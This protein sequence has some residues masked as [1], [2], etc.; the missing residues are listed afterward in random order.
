MRKVLSWNNKG[1]VMKRD[2]SPVATATAPH[3]HTHTPLHTAFCSY[4]MAGL[5]ELTFAD[6]LS[7]QTQFESFPQKACKQKN[8]VR[9]CIVHRCWEIQAFG[10]ITGSQQHDLECENLFS[11]ELRGPRGKLKGEVVGFTDHL[12]LVYAVTDLSVSKGH[13]L[14]K[15]KPANRHVVITCRKWI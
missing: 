6:E 11:L 10:I 14:E 5:T 15:L 7:V 2:V 1:S 12:A 8:K 3:T 13:D 9:E 4:L